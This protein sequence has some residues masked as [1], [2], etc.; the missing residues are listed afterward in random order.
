MRGKSSRIAT[1][2][3]TGATRKPH[4]SAARIP[5]RSAEPDSCPRSAD[6]DT[7]PGHQRGGGVEDASERRL[8]VDDR[9][10]RRAAREPCEP[11][12]AHGYEE[13]QGPAV[14]LDQS[15]PPHACGGRHLGRPVEQRLPR[16]SAPRTRRR[17]RSAA[18]TACAWGA[19]STS[20]WRRRTA[21][22]RPASAARRRTTAP[23]A[24]WRRR[25]RSSRPCPSWRRT[26]RATPCGPAGWPR[27]VLGSSFQRGSLSHSSLR[28]LTFS[29][30][31]AASA[32]V[33]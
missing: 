11:R 23:A 10:H 29:S 3:T 4:P 5:E 24:R 1:T 8:L 18:A 9:V 20:G 28:S 14:C 6:K 16:R 22:P 26:A 7:E 32:S 33:S 25:G 2:T 17:R 12:Q 19:G 21:P 13:E 30:A 27:S 31:R 15:R